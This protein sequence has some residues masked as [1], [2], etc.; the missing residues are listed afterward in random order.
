MYAA[1]AYIIHDNNFLLSDCKPAL[2]NLPTNTACRL[3]NLRQ[4]TEDLTPELP[5]Y[6]K[7]QSPSATQTKPDFA[8]PE[9][10]LFPI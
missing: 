1:S 7:I 3:A 8:N 6:Q 10:N 9:T 4:V 5:L 2:R